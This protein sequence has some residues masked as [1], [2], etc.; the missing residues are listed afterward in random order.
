MAVQRSNYRKPARKSPKK[1][2]PKSPRKKTTYNRGYTKKR[3]KSR[4]KKDDCF[5]TTACVEYYNLPDN[6]PQ[7]NLL[8]KF[9]DNYLMKTKNGQ[10]LVLKYYETAPR[11]VKKMKEDI[12]HAKLFK[13]IFQEI[14]KACGYILSENF[15]EAEKIYTNVVLSLHNRYR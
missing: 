2:S 6:C 3:Y 15:I 14:N 8:R 7:L 5:I 1:Y 12:K 13:K 4:K 9:R 11:L 10:N